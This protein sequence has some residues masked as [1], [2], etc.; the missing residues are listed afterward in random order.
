MA[1]IPTPEQAA[2]YTTGTDPRA[3]SVA[4][5]ARAGAG[6]TFTQR[7]LASRLPGSGLATS[8]LRST[9]ADL[10]KVMPSN[11]ETKG[12]HSLGYAGIRKKLPSAKVDTKGSALYEFCKDHLKDDEHWWKALPDIKALVEQAMLAGIVPD[13]ERFATQDTP[14]QWEL[15]TDRFDIDA[16]PVI[17]EAARS[18]LIH[19]N[20]L[21]LQG[22]IQ[23]THMLTLPL[24]FGYPISQYPKIIID[25]AQDL[26]ILQ[27]LLISKALR[28]NG[29]VFV[30]G[31]PCQPAGTLVSRVDYPKVGNQK[32]VVTQVPIEDIEVGDTLIGFA[33]GKSY[34]KYDAKVLGITK[35]EYQGTL[36]EATGATSTTRYTPNHICYASF[37]N[38]R[39]HTAV[40]LMEK[41]G[42]YRI[43]KAKMDYVKQ[44]GPIARAQ[45]EGASK[46][47]LLIATKDPA[48]A[49]LYEA[50]FQAQFGLPDLTFVCPDSNEQ[51]QSAYANQQYLDTFWA[52]F[53]PT[54]LRRRAVL[55]LESLGRDINFPIWDSGSTLTSFKRM[56]LF[57]AC[58]LMSNCTLIPF[59]GNNE[60]RL[61]HHETVQISRVEYTGFVYS[62]SISDDK[63]YIA[64]G[65]VTHNCQAIMAF[66]GALSNSFHELVARFSCTTLPLT[67]SWR[68]PKAVI[69]VA[70]QYV[71]DI[72]AAPTAIEG[73]VIYADHPNLSDLP[74]V[75]LCRNNAPLL[76]LAM[77]LFIAG[78]SVE[79]AGRDIGAGLKST[80]NRI[81]SSKNS[82]H[83]KADE[84]VC[85]LHNWAKREIERRPARKHSVQDKLE[86]LSTLAEHH[87]TAGSIRKHIDN[88]YVN[89][90]DG[91]RRPAEFH[92]STIHKAKG[93]EW[94]SVGFL[95]SHLIPA[96]W[97]KQEWELE[98]ESNL[99][100]VAVTRAKQ[101]LVYLDSNTIQ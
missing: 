39:D 84:F 74:R 36:I 63:L 82:D 18:A 86:A 22:T 92:L 44:S 24:F 64:D 31:D 33:Q 26:N 5:C 90:E 94:D 95:D 79:C 40:Y 53:E 75:I 50:Y 81:A 46:L 88:L 93:R 14:E 98:Q 9:V 66:S 100:Y 62:F 17:I 91:T 61:E 77:R 28:H 3:G 37:T 71:P 7:E 38:L 87:A 99:A 54:E 19:L 6:K 96:K 83:M 49:A 65:Y 42:L 13:H 35:R 47:W 48:D 29:R 51:T 70:Q 2:Y 25:E 16:S 80:I 72:Q 55:L 59:R 69:A 89:A 56:G 85:R 1:H 15:L 21:A 60:S 8:V 43:G 12:L 45:K 11:W 58:N 32:A 23:F 73:A 30:T 4:L 97:A 78:H 27:H 20:K 41:N 34:F 76:R 101:E 10:A 67:I 57:R 68:C 52:L